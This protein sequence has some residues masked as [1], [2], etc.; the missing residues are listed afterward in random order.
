MGSV[1]SKEVTR[2]EALLGA[3]AEAAVFGL[4][5]F[6]PKTSEAISAKT[7]HG[8]TQKKRNGLII[9]EAFEDLYDP[10]RLNPYGKD[11]ECKGWV[12]YIV[13]RASDGAVWP[14]SNTQNGYGDAWEGCPDKKLYVGRRSRISK[15]EAGDIIQMHYQTAKKQPAPINAYYIPHT[16]IVSRI[17]GNGFAMEWI[18]NN[19]KGDK[20]VRKHT[21]TFE[22]FLDKTTDVGLNYNVYY[23]L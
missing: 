22:T 6:L 12:Q 11:V 15:V 21:V 18:D 13:S 19:W 8:Y 9:A 14:P 4:G 2:R 3:V 1:L 16:A 7:W 10:P 20:F 23:I 17:I 5:L